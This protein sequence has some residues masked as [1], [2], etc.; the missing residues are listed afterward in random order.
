MLAGVSREPAVLTLRA[1]VRSRSVMKWAAASI[2]RSLPRRGSGRWR[3][4]RHGPRPGRAR[5]GR[6]PRRGLRRGRGRRRGVPPAARPHRERRR[7]RP[8]RDSRHSPSRAC[9]P[10]PGG[11]VPI[12]CR[13]QHCPRPVSFAERAEDAS[14]VDPGEGRHPDVARGLRLVDG[15]TAGWPR[16]RCSRRPGT[17]PVPGWRP[18]TPPSAGSR[19][20]ATSSAARAMWP[21]ASSKRCCSRASSPSMASRRTCSHGSSTMA[22][23]CSTCSQASTARSSSPAEIAARGGEQRVGGLVPGPIEIGRRAHDSGR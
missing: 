22:S 11:P 21:T 13:L 9:S 8:W 12:G 16:R 14:E 20:G 4:R 19:V 7:R 5:R 23:Q 17:A 10:P 15:A 2:R 18:G 6:R 3:G 1:S